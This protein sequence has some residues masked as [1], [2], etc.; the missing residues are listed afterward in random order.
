MMALGPLAAIF[1]ISVFDPKP[2]ADQ[3]ADSIPNV[4]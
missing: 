4:S 2:T 3:V 1:R